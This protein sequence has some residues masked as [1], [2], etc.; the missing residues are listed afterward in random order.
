MISTS[1]TVGQVIAA[2]LPNGT[3]DD[4]YA[5]MFKILAGAGNSTHETNYGYPPV[6]PT[7]LFAAAGYLVKISGVIVHFDPS[8]YASNEGGQRIVLTTE[9]RHALNAVSAAWRKDGAV[10]HEVVTFWRRLIDAW[11]EPVVFGSSVRNGAQLPSWC[12]VAFKLVVIADMALNR[13]LRDHVPSSEYGGDLWEDIVKALYHRNHEGEKPRRPPPSVTYM[14]DSSVACV[15][16]KVRVSGVGTTLRNLTRSLALLPGRGEVRCLWDLTTNDTPSED[17]ETLDILLI[18]APVKLEGKDFKPH[19]DPG[20]TARELHQYKKNWENFDLTQS[21]IGSKEKAMRFIRD[22]ER[23][24][25]KAKLES[26]CV[27]GVILPEYALNWRVFRVLCFRLKKAEPRLEFVISG[28]SDNCDGDAGNHV[29]TRIWER[30]D[31]AKKH[32]STSRSKHHRWR[33]DRSQVETYALSSALNPKI[34]YWWEN[35]QLR[36]REIHFHRFRKS[37]VMSVLICEELARSEPCH[38][39][40]RAVAPNLIIALLLDGPQIRNRWPAQYASNLA[41]DPGSSVLTFTSYGLIKRSNRQGHFDSN[42]SIA[43]WKDDSGRFVEIPMPGGEGL[44]GVLLSLW[45]DHVVDMTI[46]GKR[47]NARAWR[48]SSHYPVVLD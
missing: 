13:L 10:P 42:H 35:F 40:L 20:R 15:M 14:A 12:E 27:N 25:R 47:S 17:L 30:N 41:D 29:L 31:G 43:M 28:S 11:D 22:C 18:P 21:W 33:M 7:D 24:V 4:G 6:M 32:T 23:L 3:N 46:A 36:E 34:R 16:P 44:R 19:V 2:V 1:Q 26:G 8:P 37:S 48:Y 38:E 5:E 9:D 39:I 45:S